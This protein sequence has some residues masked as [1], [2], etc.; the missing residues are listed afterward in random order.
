MVSEAFAF[1]GAAGGQQG[2]NP[3]QGVIMLVLMFAI[4]L[5]GLNKK[6]PSCKKK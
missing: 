3:Y 4:C 1:A 5:F 2:S 6:K